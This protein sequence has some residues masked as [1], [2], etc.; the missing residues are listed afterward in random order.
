MTHKDCIRY[1]VC[2]K[3]NPSTYENNCCSL[4]RYGHEFMCVDY[5]KENDVTHY[6]LLSEKNMSNIKKLQKRKE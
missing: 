2:S 4:T 3:L 6:P 5:K 1:D